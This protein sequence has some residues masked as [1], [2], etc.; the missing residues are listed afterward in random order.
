MRKI[1]YQLVLVLDDYQWITADIVHQE[2]R[3]LLD[4]QPKNLHLL[5]SS[6]VTPP[7]HL[8]RL[9]AQRQ[10]MEVGSKDLSFTL[11]EASSFF[12]SVMKVDLDQG[13]AAALH[14]ATEGW[15]A[16]LQLAT[17]SLQGRPDRQ[18]F[19]DNLPGGN[20]K[21]YEYLIEEVLDQQDPALRDFLLKTSILSEFCAPLCD[22]ILDHTDSRELLN[23]VQQANLFVV[24]LD[25]RQ[26]WYSYHR[27]FADT[28]QRY[29]RDTYPELIPELHRKACLVAAAE[30]LPG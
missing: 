22:A 11:Q 3:Y 5:I 28:L 16:G 27:L 29:L 8:S 15:I 24:P 26:Y 17:V 2:I 19:I 20:R 6:R 30:W 25:E 1:P 12:A 18:S 4:H 10:L 14:T 23:R 7:F 13:Q 21:I 9:R